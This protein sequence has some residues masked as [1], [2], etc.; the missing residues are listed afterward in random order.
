MTTDRAGTEPPPRP[1][2]YEALHYKIAGVAAFRIAAYTTPSTASEIGQEI[3]D[4]V[5]PSQLRAALDATAIARRVELVTPVLLDH[6]RLAHTGAC[7]CGWHEPVGQHAAHLAPLV[8][9]ALQQQEPMV[10]GV[11]DA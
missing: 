7:L 10:A 6:Q 11:S 9:A 3:A 4:A 2:T 5:L 8:I 1:P